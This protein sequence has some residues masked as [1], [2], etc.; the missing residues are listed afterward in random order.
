[1]LEHVLGLWYHVCLASYHFKCKSFNDVD[2]HRGP[3]EHGKR[4]IGNKVWGCQVI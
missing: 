2:T 3:K 4:K 1:M